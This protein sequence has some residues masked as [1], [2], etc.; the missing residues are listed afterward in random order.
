MDTNGYIFS[1][2]GGKLGNQGKQ[3]YSE[4]LC[5]LILYIIAI[6]SILPSGFGQF[7]VTIAMIVA[8]AKNTATNVKA[9]GGFIAAID[10]LACITSLPYIYFVYCPC[11]LA[12]S[13]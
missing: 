11:I 13:D 12:L 5:V 4:N 6:I 7:G 8:T 10:V 3:C 2:T 1:R 9:F